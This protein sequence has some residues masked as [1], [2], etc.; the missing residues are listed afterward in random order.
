MTDN[1]IMANKRRQRGAQP[2]NRNAWKHGQY[3]A[4]VKLS[5][6]LTAARL[7]ALVHVGNSIDLFGKKY[8]PC[9][10]AM[11]RDQLE[12]LLEH[13]PQLWCELMNIAQHMVVGKH[14]M[15]HIG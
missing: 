6:K 2:G 3:S 14:R 9:V 5:R 11:R 10:R 4:Q 7:K 12:L 8:K 1:F 13:D 15:Y